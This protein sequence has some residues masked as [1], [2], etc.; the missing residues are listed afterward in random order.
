MTQHQ[1]VCNSEYQ[2]G[3]KEQLGG[4]EFSNECVQ[5]LVQEK[6]GMVYSESLIHS[7]SVKQTPE[8]QNCHDSRMIEWNPG[9]CM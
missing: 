3:Q 1:P 2:T 9:L 5:S 7:N 6:G 8:N 4:K